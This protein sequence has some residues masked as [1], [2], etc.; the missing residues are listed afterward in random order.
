MTSRAR[1]VLLGL[2]QCTAVAVAGQA[3]APP[4][5]DQREVLP[6]TVIPTH[7][8]LALSPDAQALSFTGV[9]GIAI[10]VQR[11]TSDVVLNAK[12]LTLDTATLDAAAGAAVAVDSTHDRVTL[13]FM[14]PIA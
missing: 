10:A 5:P 8:D 3:A 14:S 12:D 13:H 1:M 2:L 6:T 9:V 11:P 7:Y 4:V